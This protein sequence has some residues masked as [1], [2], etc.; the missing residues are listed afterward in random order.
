MGTRVGGGLP[1]YVYGVFGLCA[2]V[3][4]PKQPTTYGE[5]FSYWGFCT[6]HSRQNSGLQ[7][8]RLV[9]SY[10]SFTPKP[11]PSQ[12]VKDRPHWKRKALK[13]E[14]PVSTPHLFIYKL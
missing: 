1:G 9:D 11:R 7:G 12:R 2:E 10:K 4:Y 5:L 13:S 8:T 6:E 14:T 3:T